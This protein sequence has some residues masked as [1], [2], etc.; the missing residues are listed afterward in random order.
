MAQSRR[1]TNPL[2]KEA[3]KAK[4]ELNGFFGV[5]FF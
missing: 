5:N 3:V 2:I 4:K 1:S